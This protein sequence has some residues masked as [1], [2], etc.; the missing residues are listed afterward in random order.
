MALTEDAPAIKAYDEN[1]WS[2]LPDA[3]TGDVAATLAMMAGV[4]A[5]WVQAMRAMSPD[6]WRRGFNHPETGKLVILADALV[7][8]PGTVA[9]T[10]AKSPGSASST[11]GELANFGGLLLS[12]A[13]QH[14]HQ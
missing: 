14:R 2:A 9:T 11:A 13:A 5:C 1:L 3:R 4:H 10:R 7:L 6:D 8:T 12:P